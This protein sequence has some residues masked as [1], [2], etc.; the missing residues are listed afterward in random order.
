[1][2]DR[3]IWRRYRSTSAL[4]A[5]GEILWVP[6]LRCPHRRDHVGAESGRPTTS[7]GFFHHRIVDD[8][9]RRRRSSKFVATRCKDCARRGVY[10]RLLNG[11]RYDSVAPTRRRPVP[12]NRHPSGSD[13]VSVH[14]RALLRDYPPRM[15]AVERLDRFRRGAVASREAES[16]SESRRQE[17]QRDD[18]PV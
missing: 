14:L 10:A 16:E 17:S 12:R 6:P 15:S 9:P 4:D 11:D 3:L 7:A 5:I 2:H 8:S 18:V 1:M 13:D